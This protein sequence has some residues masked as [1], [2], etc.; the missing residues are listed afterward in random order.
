MKGLENFYI[1]S[2]LGDL[3]DI[4]YPEGNFQEERLTDL[5]DLMLYAAGTGFTPMIRLI[6]HCL[7]VDNK[8]DR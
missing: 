6:Y 8:P 1:F 7:Y 5:S 4:S 3:I 2:K